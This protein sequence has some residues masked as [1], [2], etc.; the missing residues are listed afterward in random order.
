MIAEYDHATRSA[1]SGAIEQLHVHSRR[2]NVTECGC[3]KDAAQHCSCDQRPIFM[4]TR[5][6]HGRQGTQGTL[7]RALAKLVNTNPVD[8]ICCLLALISNDS[9]DQLVKFNKMLNGPRS[10]SNGNNIYLKNLLRNHA[11]FYIILEM[12]RCTRDRNLQ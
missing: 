9:V 8:L 4:N 1:V 7:M 6:R 10:S 3:D 12:L 5:G 2:L 11:K